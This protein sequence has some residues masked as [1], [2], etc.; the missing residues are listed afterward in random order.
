[1]SKK[2][3][4]QASYHHGDLRNALITAGLAILEE[5]GVAA[6]S[7]RSVARRANVSHAAPYRHFDDKTALLA[8]IAIQG[9]QM[10][11]VTQQQAIATFPDDPLQQ[12]IEIGVQ[13]VTFGKAH[14]AHLALMFSNLLASG[15]SEALG[16]EAGQTFTTLQD[17]IERAQNAGLIT[18]GPPRDIA[19]SVWAMIHGFAMLTKEG[20][21]H[22]P[23]YPK[24]EDLVKQAFEQLMT[25][26]QTN[27]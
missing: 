2:N 23:Y 1:M 16:Q 17:T 8:A 20:L 21:L 25:G 14:P 12:L 22:A 15:S 5:E 13:Y 7:L 26:L 24:T 4:E 3:S 6:L 9:F 19:V 18:E 10:L 27:S 11:S